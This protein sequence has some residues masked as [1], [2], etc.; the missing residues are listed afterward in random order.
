MAVTASETFLE[1]Y[2]MKPER[3]KLMTSSARYMVGGVGL[4]EHLLDG[5]DQLIRV[6][7]FDDP[8]GRSR[9]LAL[10]FLFLR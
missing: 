4:A 1:E 2:G 5:R 8:T 6:E 7:R 3:S 10:R 9:R